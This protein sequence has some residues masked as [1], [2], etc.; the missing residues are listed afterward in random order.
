MKKAIKFLFILL[1]L[2]LVGC[3]KKE[4]DTKKESE[5]AKELNAY[6][7]GIIPQVM[8][9][10]FDI[11]LD[12][13]FKDGKIALLE[14]ES[15]STN[16]VGISKKGRVT[17]LSSLFD[18][19]AK[20]K[21]SIFIDGTLKDEVE[22]EINVKGEMS[23]DEYKHQFEELYIPTSIYKDIQFADKEDIIFGSRKIVGD[24]T[25]TSSDESILASNGKYKNTNAGDQTI[26]LNYNV[27]IN[28]FT[29]T[30]S[31]EVLI[32]G[33][34]NEEIVNHASDWLDDTW[35]ISTIKGDLEFPKTDDVGKVDIYFES[36]SKDIIDDSGKFVNWCVNKDVIFNAI[37]SINGYSITKEIRMKTIS[38]EEALEYIFN[39]MHYEDYYQ[40]YFYTYIVSGGH[41]NTDY[42]MFNF[43]TLDLDEASLILRETGS[44]YTYGKKGY[45]TNTNRSEFEVLMVP[46][47][48]TVKRPLNIKSSTEFITVHD[49]GD[50][51]FN[52]D[53]WANEVT[54]SSRQVSWH[55]TVDD[56][57]IIQHIPLDEVAYHAGDGGSVFGLKDT[58]VKYTVAKPTISVN[59]DGYYVING[60]ESNLKAPYAD[61]E[62]QKNITPA[63]IYTQLGKNGN[64]YMNNTYYNSTYDKISN[65]GGNYYSIGI[66][67]CVHNG[68]EYSKVQKRLAN[69]VA[70]LLNLYDLNPSRVLQHRNFSGKYCPQSMIRATEYGQKSQFTLESFYKMVDIEYFIIKYLPDLKVEYTS[71][72]PDILSNDGEILSYVSESTKVKY[73]V[74]ASYNGH[75]FEHTYETTIHSKDE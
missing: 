13:N 40:S 45:N 30:G 8:E 25:W 15:L 24:I 62:Y 3:T 39:Q 9:K 59:D 72:N 46:R 69:L 18:C 10:S 36:G 7:E 20:V 48:L 26:S 28:D 50:N 60:Q 57:K 4:D 22:Y 21:C 52:A 32:E 51:K 11:P 63:G 38:E 44:N 14:W 43:Y 68:V 27:L 41:A 37:I 74:K 17:Y 71:L 61:G 42:G 47:T 70:H 67:S 65:C 73:Q 5:Y 33:N 66:E 53:Q 54:T 23:V 12:F 19:N 49:T 64:Y 75:T 2:F 56:K 16:A 1:I 31:K 6:M 29:I 34:H 55:F 35:S 58:G